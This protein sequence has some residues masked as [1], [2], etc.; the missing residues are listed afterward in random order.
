MLLTENTEAYAAMLPFLNQACFGS[1][2]IL[3]FQFSESE[4]R[5]EWADSML[6]PRDITTVDI[7]EAARSMMNKNSRVSIGRC[8]MIPCNILFHEM[9]GIDDSETLH[10]YVET[11]KGRRC[12][13]L[14]DSWLYVFHSHVAFLAVGI[15]FDEIQTLADIV[16]L[17]GMN[18]RA[19]FCYEDESGRVDFSLSEWVDNIAAKSGLHGFFS[20]ESNPFADVFTY[21]LAVIPERF[22]NLEV[23]KQATF[24]LH[25]MIPFSNPVTDNSEE[26]V[27]F[28]Y[29]KIGEISHT[30]RWAACVTSQTLSYIVGDPNMDFKGQMEIRG[31]AGL[32][33]VMFALYEKYTCI[34]YTEAIADTDIHHLNPIQNL[35]MEMLE[36]KAYGTLAPSNISRWSNIRQIYRALLETNEIPSAIAD[37]DYKIGILA[38]HQREIESKRAGM[39]TN[40]ITAFGIVSILESVLAIIQILLG[41]NNIIWITLLLT[42]VV[43]FLAFLLALFRRRGK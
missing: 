17:G 15:C 22:P 40:L 32:P 9:A 33:I 2:L 21:T 6:I 12:F 24:N 7:N 35:K 30:Y 13:S 1:Y 3:P 20:R 8:W 26:D 23:M 16:N 11:E 10:L 41:A 25:L 43:L 36:F 39:L 4:F 14:T 29:A 27:R 31:R 18:S 42:T 28:V 37:V 34:R 19:A 5:F 38:E